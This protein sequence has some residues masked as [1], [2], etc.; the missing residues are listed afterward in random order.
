MMAVYSG[1]AIVLSTLVWVYLSWL[2]LLIGAELAF[3]VQFP[4]YLPHRRES[5]VLT[6]S[7]RERLSL[8]VMYLIARD[9]C[10]GPAHWN[11]VRLA[12][13]LDVPA[14]SLAPV[15]ASLEKAHLIAV[16]EG[17]HFLPGRDP[18]NLRISS[19]IEAVRAPQSDPVAPAGR[20]AAP[21]ARVMREVEAALEQGL[22]DRSV[23]DMI[24]WE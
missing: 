22:G 5:T 15:L 16:T 12:A 3:Y 14:T 10:A 19:V 4:Q 18:A 6:G 20:A 8:A 2:I 9:Y 1:F 17:G 7:A 24:G 21:A 23:K 11:A 13:E